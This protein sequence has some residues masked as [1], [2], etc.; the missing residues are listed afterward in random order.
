[1]KRFTFKKLAVLGVL[2]AAFPGSASAVSAMDR[3]LPNSHGKSITTPVAW[4][5]AY[6][7]MFIGVGGTS[8]A[9]HTNDTDGGVAVGFGIGNPVRQV[10]LQAS[11]ASL[12]LSEWDRFS[13]NL[14]LHRYLGSASSIA[15][16]VENI[17]IAGA[18][19]TDSEES[20]YIV[21]SKGVLDSS[22]INEVT[23]TTKLHYSIG[24]GSGRFGEKSPSDIAAGKSKHGTYV[25]G[26]VA[27]ELFGQFNL[28]TDW[29][30]VN[31]NAGISKTFS[32][33]RTLPVVI[34]VGAADL[35]DNSGDGVRF[36]GGIG[37]GFRL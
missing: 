27:Y 15:V 26:N 30:G 7:T 4:G 35:T 21:F 5:A 22:L 18:D 8:P 16:G 20:F 23:N 3:V 11:V 2:L 31:L 17:M 37:T 14:H 10:G 24:V 29:N 1:M 9:P 32:I 12:D 6:G 13:L 28:V 36:V 25:F 33:N 34:T 19:E